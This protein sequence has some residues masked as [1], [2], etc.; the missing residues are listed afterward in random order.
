MKRGGTL[1]KSALLPTTAVLLGVHGIEEVVTKFADQARFLGILAGALRV[2][3]SAVFVLLQCAWIGALVGLGGRKHVSSRVR[4]GV[5]LTVILFELV[6][7]LESVRRHAYVPGLFTS[8]LFP[9]LLVP[10]LAHSWMEREPLASSTGDSRSL[11]HRSR[12]PRG[13]EGRA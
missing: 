2:P 3:P 1:S 13:R 8:L 10:L 7:P 12:P 11:G 9:L 5:V 4:T 6:H